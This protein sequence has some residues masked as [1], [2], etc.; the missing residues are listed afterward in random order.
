[1]KE[2]PS[3]EE[4]NNHAYEEKHSKEGKSLQKNND[5]VIL[6]FLLM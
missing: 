6:F 4:V 5:L 3:N 2:V 1:M